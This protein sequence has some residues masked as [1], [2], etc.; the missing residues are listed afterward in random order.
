MRNLFITGGAGYLGRALLRTLSK[1]DVR[2]TIFSRDHGKHSRCQREFP[3]FRY[4]IGDVRDYN[5]VELAMAGH[6]T[7]IHCAAFKYVPEG[8]TNVVEC[9]E[10]NV[11]GSLNVARAAMRN[12]V[13]NVIGIS[14]DKACQPINVYGMTKLMMER[15]F[16]EADAKGSTQFNLVRYG[17]VV[18]STGSAIPLFR[19][20]VIEN[21]HVLITNPKMTRFWLSV[22]DGVELIL[23]A[24][25]EKQG[26]TILIPRL[27]SLNMMD[28]ARTVASLEDVDGVEFE[29]IGVRFGEK[30]H[31]DLL[32]EIESVHAEKTLL[33]N[34]N[35]MAGI[36]RLYPMT[37]AP[38]SEHNDRYNSQY[39]DNQLSI[40]D[41]KAMIKQAVD[42]ENEDRKAHQERKG[43]ARTMLAHEVF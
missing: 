37:S 26:G 27:P 3:Q 22:D 30:M 2:C 35:M 20:Q 28:V 23:M 17:N 42:D 5:S 6:D 15:I 18:S 14:T 11:M 1:E 31:E 41:A 4:I 25:E 21:R 7:V 40:D 13:E 8:E 10:I 34:P 24:L 36:M 38:L 16:Q 9:H 12:N 43:L 29:E 33:Y 39:P 19:R 32:G